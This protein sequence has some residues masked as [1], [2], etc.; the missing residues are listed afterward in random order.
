MIDKCK[1]I[2]LPKITDPRGN[3][4]FVEG[5]NHVEFDIR[6][7]FYLYDV[8]TGE[9]RGAHAHRELRQ[10]LICLSGSFDVTLD[11]GIYQT[12]MHLNRP[13]RGLYIPPMIWASEVNFDPGTVCLVL[14]SDKYKEKDYFRDYNDYLAARGLPLI[15]QSVRLH[16]EGVNR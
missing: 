5:G 7:V 15:N 11:D 3:L 4:T 6:R 16:G 1:I 12:T 8:P 14:A 2:D 13:W 10:F 9:S